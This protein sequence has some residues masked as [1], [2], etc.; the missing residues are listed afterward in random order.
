MLKIFTK[1]TLKTLNIAPLVALLALSFLSCTPKVYKINRIEGKQIAIDSTIAPNEKVAQFILPYQEKL[2]KEM[3]VILAYTP[4]TLTRERNEPETSLGNFVADLAL[5]RAQ[6]KF[7]D[8]TGK[9]IDF[10]LL[11]AG[12]LRSDL[13]KGNVTVGNAYEVMPFENSLIVVE[14]DYDKFLELLEYYGVSKNPH[15][16]SH[17]LKLTFKDDKLEKYA[18]NGTENLKLKSYYVLTNDYLANGGD[19]M[20]FF[21]NPISAT[22]INYKVRDAL[23]DELI[24]ID[25]INQTLDNRVER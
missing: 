5:K 21:L 3:E 19:N 15:P 23:L 14:I 24:A 25:T 2:N 20:N 7:Y 9:N 6:T 12:G 18:L 10:V 17:N 4:T 13:N 11:N 1:Q 22:E 16:I 8:L